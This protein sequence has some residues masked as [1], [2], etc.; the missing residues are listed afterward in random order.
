MLVTVSHPAHPSKTLVVRAEQDMTVSETH[1][2]TA[3]NETTKHT[4]SAGIGRGGRPVREGRSRTYVRFDLGALPKP[5]AL[6]SVSIDTATLHLFVLAHALTPQNQHF[7]GKRYLVSVGSCRSSDWSESTMSWETR[8]CADEWVSLDTKIVDGD[9]LPAPHTWNVTE[10]FERAV[11]AGLPHATLI[12]D[13]QRLLNCSRDPLEGRG[14]PDVERV[15]FLRFASRERVDF[16]ISVVP[17]VVVSYSKL[18]TSLMTYLTSTL[19]VLSAIAMLVGL[20]G[21]IRGL[22][23]RKG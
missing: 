1:P 13:A 21:A 23:K 3:Q 19:A 20:Y 22:R 15:G 10:E 8:L 17:R 9:S 4:L 14:C 2:N 12:V 18:P 11:S 7:M 16:G 5:N 6:Q